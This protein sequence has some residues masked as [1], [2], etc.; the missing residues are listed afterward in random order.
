MVGEEEKSLYW[1]EML[2]GGGFRLLWRCRRPVSFRRIVGSRKWSQRSDLVIVRDP[3]WE[4]SRWVDR[5]DLCPG[6]RCLLRMDGIMVE[7]KGL[8][9]RNRCGT[10]DTGSVR[11]VI[12]RRRVDGVWT[13]M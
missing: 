13:R 5:K 7:R 6:D 8:Y 9:S 1:R 3:R 10:C 11:V 2:I 12:L 4:G